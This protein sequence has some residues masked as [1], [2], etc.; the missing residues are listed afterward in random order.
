MAR[1]KVYHHR[2]LASALKRAGA[3]P[4][5]SAKAVAWA[6]RYPTLA[7]AAI[8]CRNPYRIYWA[9]KLATGKIASDLDETLDEAAV[10]VN[11]S[12]ITHDEYHKACNRA[13][14]HA[15][16]AW[17]RRADSLVARG[18]RAAKTRNAMRRAAAAAVAGNS[19]GEDHWAGTGRA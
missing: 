18:K 15:A 12:V 5:Q 1:A 14:R 7:A 3:C 17:A 9:S 10:A 4:S 11:G 19:T 16:I 8:A 6:G 13:E 2:A